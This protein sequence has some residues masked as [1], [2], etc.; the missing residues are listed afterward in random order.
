MGVA[1]DVLRYA[2]HEGTPYSAESSASH[3]YEVGAQFFCQPGNMLG[4]ITG[5]LRIVYPE[6]GLGDGSPGFFN[7]ACKLAKLLSRLCLVLVWCMDNG[8]APHVDDV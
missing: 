8:A 5:P 3:Y 4:F 1:H 7:L 2:P 6:V